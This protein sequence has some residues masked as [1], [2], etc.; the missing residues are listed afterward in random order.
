M[1]TLIALSV[2]A[3]ADTVPADGDAV[4]PGSQTLVDLGSASPGQVVNVPVSF[5]LTCA[6]TTH[7]ARGSTI[8]LDLGSASIPTDGDAS[9]TSTTIGPVPDD[10]TPNG[11]GCPTPEPTFA[12]TDPS[13]VTLTMPPTAHDND[14]F[15]LQWDRS[16]AGGLSSFSIVTFQI[17]VVGNTPPVLHIPTQVSAEAT[18]SA[19]ADVTWSATATDKE[20]A[21]P[22]TPT[23]APAS[24]STFPLGITT[25]KCSVTDGGG[26]KDS[27]SF[28][29]SVADG[30]PP[31]LVGM[32]ADQHLTTGDP[33]GTTL[34]YTAPT[35]TDAADPSPTVGCT[36][37]SGT[38]VDVGTTTVTCTAQDGTGNHSSA[39]FSV[40]VR[41]VSPVT[42]SAVWGEPVATSGGVFV[43]NPGRTVPVKVELFANGVEQTHGTGALTMTTCAGAAAGSVALTWDGGRWVGHIDTS[44]LRGPGC[45][46]GTA[47]LDGNVAGSFRLDLRGDPTAASPAAPKGKLN[48]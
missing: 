38:H 19:G 47:S 3:Y 2:A 36:P 48:G 4:T 14:L 42:W 34:T 5:I 17:D 21:N 40:D 45:Y 31:K 13:I 29:V 12:G 9:A 22:P 23:C 20:D 39:S 16:G 43:A 18:S 33:N 37:A 46:T 8:T 24:G 7:A 10:W 41:F 44:L 6:G 28:L 11:E 27:G 32:P 35:A 30:I 25:V 15:T 1:A 26:L